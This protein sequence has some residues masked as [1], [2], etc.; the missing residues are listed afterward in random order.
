LPYALLRL[1]PSVATALYFCSL[2][3]IEF[4]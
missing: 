4:P 3:D 2:P 1:P